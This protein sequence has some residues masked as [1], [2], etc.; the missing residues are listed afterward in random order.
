MTYV[1]AK[2]DNISFVI[3]TIVSTG[4]AFNMTLVTD[5]GNNSPGTSIVGTTKTFASGLSQGYYNA[6][7]NASVLRNVY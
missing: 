4:Q 6:S 3:G 1:S 5:S 7:I 2:I